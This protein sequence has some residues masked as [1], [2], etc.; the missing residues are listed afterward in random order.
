MINKS[1]PKRIFY[2]KIVNFNY[3][4][5]IGNEILKKLNLKP[6]S[7]ENI[8]FYDEINVNK[9]NIQEIVLTNIRLVCA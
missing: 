9:K 4:L 1:R 7:Y 6:E 5:A 2:N 3:Q 8:L